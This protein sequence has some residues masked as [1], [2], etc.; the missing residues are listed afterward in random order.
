MLT[1][2]ILAYIGLKG[3][4]ALRLDIGEVD[5]DEVVELVQD[6]YRRIAPKGLAALVKMGE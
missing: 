1:P 6:S 3:W 5:W 4:V 2:Y